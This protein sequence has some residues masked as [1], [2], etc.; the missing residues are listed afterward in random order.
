MI[1]S[2]NGDRDSSKD[3]RLTSVAV[4]ENVSL[5]LKLNLPLNLAAMALGVFESRHFD[6]V[7]M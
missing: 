6:L 1:D 5:L 3:D 4:A 7:V 2:Q